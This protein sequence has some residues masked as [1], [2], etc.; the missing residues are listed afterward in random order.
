MLKDGECELCEREMPLTKHHV[1]PRELHERYV[2]KGYKKKV[3]N[4]GIY[5]RN[6]LYILR[7][8]L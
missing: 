7:K 8:I 4:Q 5:V 2:K 1:I 6:T 3:L